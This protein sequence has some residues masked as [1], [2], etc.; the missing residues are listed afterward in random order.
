MSHREKNAGAVLG[1]L[2]LLRVA[3]R[4]RRMD[5][6][7]GVAMEVSR[8][9]LEP[10]V[11]T[12]AAAQDENVL[13]ADV[14]MR[15]ISP[16]RRHPDQDRHRGLILRVGQIDPLHPRVTGVLPRQAFEARVDPQPG[17][18]H[19][20]ESTGRPPPGALQGSL[21][22]SDGVSVGQFDPAQRNGTGASGCPVLTIATERMV[23]TAVELGDAAI[24]AA[25]LREIR[26]HGLAD[27][28]T[29][30]R[31]GTG[32]W[33]VQRSLG[34]PTPDPESASAPG[35]RA[36]GVETFPL[37]PERALVISGPSNSTAASRDASRDLVDALATLAGAL[38]TD[39][40]LYAAVDEADLVP[41]ALPGPLSGDQ[42]EG[43]ARD[44]A[45]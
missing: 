6:A 20:R 2:G 37:G 10:V 26:V 9:E 3:E 7:R 44:E 23:A 32:A 1:A 19:I 31:R 30:W 18:F 25:L 16:T 41:P 21:R 27:R 4:H 8:G 43:K 12:I 42:D 5:T 40:D 22:K 11:V 17:D 13:C 33:V 45:A 24:P 38:L 15:G 34:G 36:V 35:W 39:P 28:A 29:I 14:A